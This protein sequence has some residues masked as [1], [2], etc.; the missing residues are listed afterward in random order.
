[1]IDDSRFSTQPARLQHQEEFEQLIQEKLMEAPAEDWLELMNIEDIA[2]AP[3]NT[4]D[5]T[6]VDPQVQHR[7][8]VLDLNHPLG[9]KVKLVGNPLKM[10]DSIDDSSYRPPPTLGQH[11]YEVFGELLGYSKEKIDKLLG[12]GEAHKNALSRHLHKRL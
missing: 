4:L 11:N 1:M 2:A 7:N 10:P 5:K 8:M 3:V 9:G 12:E 6:A